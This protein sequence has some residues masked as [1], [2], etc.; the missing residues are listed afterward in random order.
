MNYIIGV[1]S[2]GTSTKAIAYDERGNPLFKASGGFGNL[3]NNKELAL[4]HLKSTVDT[5]LKELGTDNCQAIIFGIA[6]VDAGGFRGDVEEA[7]KFY[8]GEI[9]V[10]ND[11]WLAHYALL[12]GQDGCLVISGTGSIVLG[13]AGEQQGRVGGWGNLLGDEGSGYDIAKHL[14]L[15]VLDAYDSGRPLTS[16]EAALYDH[17]N[18]ETPFALTHFV[19]NA[20]KDQI[21][22]LTLLIAD[23]AKKGDEQAKRILE[24]AGQALGRQATLLL[25]K[26]NIENE[27]LVAVTGSVLIKNDL[28]FD[29][30][31]NEILKHY[32]D[33]QFIRKEHSNTLGAYYFYKNPIVF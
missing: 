31:K 14:I 16:L 6:G 19:Y 2:G 11:A 7:F 18:I 10:L 15:A 24:N 13:K 3:L 23:T 29:A 22:Q 17:L 1:D 12:E 27:P 20:S 4:D 30:F 5:I 26:L 28:V 33:S 9:V 8:P 25:Q 32:S 21:A